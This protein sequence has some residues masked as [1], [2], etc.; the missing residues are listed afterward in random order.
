[1]DT[2][3]NLKKSPH[4]IAP[5]VL[6]AEP[7][8]LPVANPSAE[9][10]PLPVGTEERAP[11]GVRIANLVAVIVPLAA[12]LIAIVSLWGRGFTWLDFGLLL[13]M[14]ALTVLG[15]TVGFHRLFT[16]RSFETSAPVAFIFG[17]LGSMAVQG[18]LFNWVALHRR[19]HQH[20]DE[21][22]D[23]HSPHLAGGG[24]WGVLRGMWHAHLGWLFQRNR[25]DLSRYAKDLEQSFS[26]RVANRL[27]FFWVALGLLLPAVISGLIGG[28]WAA[29]FWGFM[30][31]G[32]VRI[33]LVHHVTW[34]VNSV[35]HL[36]GRRPYRSD[37]KS[38]NNFLFGVLAFG[39]GWHNTHH[40]FPTSARH[41]LRWWQLDLSYW[42]I[43]ALEMMG[44][45][46]NV[47]LP[48]AQAQTNA[49]R[50]T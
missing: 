3:D 31:G 33:L 21:P 46:W 22:G 48:S 16:H 26:L 4:P 38:R 41:G 47:K 34:S 17:V 18:R 24:P 9:L 43:R 36:W 42:I 28:T 44:M 27:F 10:P 39:E 7:T 32:L 35:C 50:Q 19:H 5:E 20:S 30:W 2:P 1:M 23:P 40:A 49:S 29:A 12:M 11:L 37:D 6:T 25:P 45:A 14:Y 15:I 8:V 13:G